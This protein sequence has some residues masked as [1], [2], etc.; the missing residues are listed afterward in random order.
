MTYSLPDASDFEFNL[1]KTIFLGKVFGKQFIF[2]NLQVINL[3]QVLQVETEAGVI[4]L[5]LFKTSYI[6]LNTV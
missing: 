2:I 6:Y 4:K 1:I 3:A 5:S